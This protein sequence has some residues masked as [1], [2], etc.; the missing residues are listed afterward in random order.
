[1]KYSLNQNVCD[2]NY[3]IQKGAVIDN[4][5]WSAV[6]SYNRTYYISRLS[7]STFINNGFM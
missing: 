5:V 1:M 7:L 4:Q 2:S 3:N 6:N